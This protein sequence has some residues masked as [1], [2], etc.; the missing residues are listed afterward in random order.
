MNDEA[1]QAFEGHWDVVRCARALKDSEERSVRSEGRGPQQGG[2]RRGALAASAPRAVSC[3]SGDVV[4][5]AGEI[6]SRRG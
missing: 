6:F 1:L 3:E 5:V 4:A 2:E